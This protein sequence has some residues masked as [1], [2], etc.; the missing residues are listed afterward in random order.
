MQQLLLIQW[1]NS[2]EFLSWNFWSRVLKKFYNSLPSL[3]R[4]RKPS[5]CSIGGFSS[6]KRIL[7]ASQT[8]KLP[9][10]IFVH[11]KVL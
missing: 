5:R 6:S 3:D 2:F 4:R 1:E 10:D 7:R 8:W 11:W 9:I